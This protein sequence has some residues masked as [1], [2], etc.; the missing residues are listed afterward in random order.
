MRKVNDKSRIGVELKLSSGYTIFI[1]PLAP[2]YMD[3]V[4]DA[5]PMPELPQRE[6]ELLGGDKILWEYIPPDEMPDKDDE[7][8]FN[9]YMKW[10][11]IND[12]RKK[13]AEDRIR[14]KRDYLYST[15]VEIVEGPEDFS[16]DGW[17]DKLEAAFVEKGYQ[18]PEH[19][20]LLRLL[21]LKSFVIRTQEEADL[22][23][24]YSMFPEVTMQGILNALNKFP[25]KMEETASNGTDGIARRRRSRA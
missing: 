19:E 25:D 7:Y 24:Q 12:I 13:I 17:I 23:L 2:Y 8:E 5:L 16:E 9:L 4:G 6:I 11:S 18:V 21:F 14:A 20:G 3:I 15:C 22:I 1:T 10:Q